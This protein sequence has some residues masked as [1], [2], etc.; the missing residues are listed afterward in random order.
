MEQLSAG[1]KDMMSALIEA[2]QAQNTDKTCVFVTN[3]VGSGN[4]SRKCSC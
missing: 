2:V 3:E 1:A 4:S